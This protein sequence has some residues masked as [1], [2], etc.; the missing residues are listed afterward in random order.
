MFCVLNG[1]ICILCWVNVWYSF[2]VMVFLLVLFV[3]FVISRFD[4]CF[5]KVFYFIWVV[6]LVF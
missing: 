3:V 2:V 6:E 4:I 5:L 1:V